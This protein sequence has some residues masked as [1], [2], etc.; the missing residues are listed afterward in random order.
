MTLL[1]S[2]HHLR[3]PR[4]LRRG[5]SRHLAGGPSSI[6][7][8]FQEVRMSGKVIIIIPSQGSDTNAFADTARKLKKEVYPHATIIK[9]VLTD[10]G[11]GENRRTT[12][13]LQTLDGHEFKLST[14]HNISRVITVSHGFVNDG[15]NMAF[16]DGNVRNH[17]PW[18]ST[19][20]G[21][22]LTDEAQSFW[23]DVGK[24]LNNHGKIL[25]LGCSMGSASYAS[26]VAKASGRHVFAATDEIAA[27]NS[28]STLKLVHSIENGH[29][30]KPMKDFKP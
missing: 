22:D 19:N 21:A 15:P 25:L 13:T 23:T 28:K 14:K 26:N 2:S 27:G 10:V 29:A 9:T 17:Q 3:S 6:A 18:A 5:R 11:E 1:S 12:V 7:S 20:G 16:G 24:S 4:G 30:R 8:F